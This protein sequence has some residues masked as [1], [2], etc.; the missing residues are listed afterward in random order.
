MSRCKRMKATSFKDVFTAISFLLLTSSNFLCAVRRSRRKSL[1]IVMDRSYCSMWLTETSMWRNTYSTIK[2]NL[3]S[4]GDKSTI[5]SLPLCSCLIVWTAMSTSMDLI[6]V[7]VSIILT[8]QCLHMDQ[9]RV[10][11][12]AVD[13]QLKGTIQRFK[14]K[15]VWSNFIKCQMTR[16]IDFRAC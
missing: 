8:R 7:T 15:D 3:N 10:F 4:L 14:T 9:T 1:L 12:T 6:A 2:G 11:S 5:K 16:W 13:R